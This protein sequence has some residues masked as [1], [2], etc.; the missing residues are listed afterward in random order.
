MKFA[1]YYLGLVC[2]ALLSP[3]LFLIFKFPNIRIGDTAE[4]W[5]AIKN[6][7]IQSLGS[8]ILILLLSFVGVLGLACADSIDR[9]WKFP[10]L[11]SILKFIFLLPSFLPALFILLSLFQVIDPFPMGLFGICFVHAFMYW[12]LAAVVLADSV[13]TQSGNLIEVASL[14][15]ASPWQIVKSILIPRHFVELKSLFFY[16]FVMCFISFSIPLIVGGGKGTTIEVLIY[17]KIRISGDWG[18]ALALSLIQSGI[19][20]YLSWLKQ[21]TLPAKAS[22]TG[23]LAM[24][25]SK[26]AL[27]FSLFLGM[28]P[29][30]GYI[31][32]A[33]QSL[34]QITKLLEVENDLTSKILSSIWLGCFTGVIA[35]S[36]LLG[37]I[38][39]FQN[40]RMLK[41][42]RSFASASTA[43]VGFY[44][45]FFG[46]NNHI[47]PYWK[48]PVGMNLLCFPFLLRMG[49]LDLMESKKSQIDVANLLGASDLTIAKKILMP[50]LVD[51]AA[52]L[53]AYIGVWAVGDFALGKI[54]ANSDFSVAMLTESLMSSYRTGMAAVVSLLLI[55][56]GL[57]VYFSL[58]SLK[59]VFRN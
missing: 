17:E 9:V 19:V 54:L 22:E 26:L 14:L 10:I 37:S 21:K 53:S 52:T 29:V 35:F 43:L 32:G 18:P 1:R 56:I 7:L 40:F 6:T 39:A 4:L 12:G 45:L 50:Q 41:L 36:L 24:L 16:F 20:I 49:W 25:G 23:G 13:R 33:V 59:Y 31:S 58:R 55:P 5:W 30:Y 28:I 47:S 38:L 15:G 3:Y 51:R 34:P 2:F 27:A 44:L 11:K 8:A 42:L 57:I 46:P 48:I